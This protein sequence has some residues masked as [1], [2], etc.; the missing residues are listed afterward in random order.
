M[1]GGPRL[2]LSASPETN[3]NNK[4]HSAIDHFRSSKGLKKLSAP[5]QAPSRSYLTP[6]CL[7]ADGSEVP[8]GLACLQL[9]GD[10]SGARSDM[11][12]GLDW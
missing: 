11:L 5:K 8:A 4:Q 3:G 1:R 12:D 9:D 7:G 6:N 2:N 10:A